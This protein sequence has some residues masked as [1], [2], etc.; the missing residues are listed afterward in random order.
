MGFVAHT[1]K[2][3]RTIGFF[4][5]VIGGLAACVILAAGIACENKPAET[6]TVKPDLPS[7]RT[8]LLRLT[9]EELSRMQL[10]LVSVAQGQLLSHREFPATVQANQNELAEVTTL[11][12]GRVMKVHVD[13]GQDV[14]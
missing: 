12:R 9:P 3:Q 2:N 6:S 13:V 1:R 7:A 4:I 11:I 14:K 8:G 5:R 10:E